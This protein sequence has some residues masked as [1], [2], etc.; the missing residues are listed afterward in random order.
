MKV[1]GNVKF[2]DSKSEL[3]IFTNKATY[4]KNQET[5]FTEGDSVAINLEN[6][7]T[8]EKFKYNR[9]KD[10][11]E[12]EKNVEFRDKREIFITSEKATYIHDKEN[13]LQIMRYYCRDRKKYKFNSKNVFYFK[14]TQTIYSNNK[15]SIQDDNGNLYELKSF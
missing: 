6:T 5:I 10:I 7:I 13:Y 1:N 2:E 9:L 14:D 3:L 12:A 8:T 15:S 4:F 11:L